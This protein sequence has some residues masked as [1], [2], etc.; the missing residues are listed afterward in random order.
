MLLKE[1][2][3]HPMEAKLSDRLE[4]LI[5]Q[6]VIQQKADDVLNTILMDRALQ[7]LLVE[8]RSR[9]RMDFITS[10]RIRTDKAVA[11]ASC[12]SFRST[13]TKDLCCSTPIQIGNCGKPQQLRSERL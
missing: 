5:N 11:N 7:K 9:K 2:W 3:E 1:T 8:E 10:H 13:R 12:E 4:R 6:T